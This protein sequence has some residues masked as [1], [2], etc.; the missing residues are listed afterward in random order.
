MLNPDVNLGPIGD[1]IIFENEH[2][3]VWELAVEPGTSGE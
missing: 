2:V 1:R 3:R